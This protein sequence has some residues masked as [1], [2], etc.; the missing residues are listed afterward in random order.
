MYKT[1]KEI[2]ELNAQGNRNSWAPYV[3]TGESAWSTNSIRFETKSECE[4]YC[5]DLKSRWVLVRNY[6]ACVSD[7][8]PDHYFD[9]LNR[10]LV[11]L[12]DVLV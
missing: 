2:E 5:E 6:I 7:D 9:E 8:E 10:E 11:R 1:L 12:E 4:R 3:D